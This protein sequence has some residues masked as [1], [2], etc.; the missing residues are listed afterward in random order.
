M[1]SEPIEDDVESIAGFCP[2]VFSHLTGDGSITFVVWG[3][4]CS[5]KCLYLGSDNHARR[6]FELLPPHNAVD[7]P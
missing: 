7:F 5:A 2:C 4:G 3:E 6:I 1:K